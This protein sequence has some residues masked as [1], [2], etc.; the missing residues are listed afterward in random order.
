MHHDK[1]YRSTDNMSKNWLSFKT[2][3]YRQ[4][5]TLDTENNRSLKS[6]P[7]HENVDKLEVSAEDTEN[8]L[9]LSG[10]AQELS[11]K[12]ILG[13]PKQEQSSKF[14]TNK[15][16]SPSRS[17][18]D[19]LLSTSGTFSPS[20]SESSFVSRS[21]VSSSETSFVTARDSLTS[22]TCTSP[23]GDSEIETITVADGTID[24]SSDSADTL[25]FTLDESII[26]KDENKYPLVKQDPNKTVVDDFEIV[27]ID[28]DKEDLKSNFVSEQHE[29]VE[30]GNVDEHTEYINSSVVSQDVTYL[31]AEESVSEEGTSRYASLENIYNTVLHQSHVD[32][33]EVSVVGL[34]DITRTA[35]YSVRNFSTT[36][37]PNQSCVDQ[38]IEEITVVEPIN[39]TTAK[40][41]VLETNNPNLEKSYEGIDSESLNSS[42]QTINES[43][44]TL[45]N[46]TSSHSDVKSPES[47]NA[48]ELEKSIVQEQI[49]K[50][51]GEIQ[52]D[53]INQQ[54]NELNLNTEFSVEEI[55]AS[56]LKLN[57]EV[58]I[59]IQEVVEKVD[60]TARIENSSD[61][62]GEETSAN[63]IENP[64]EPTLDEI[65]DSR[66]LVV[67]ES[68]PVPQQN[69][70]FIQQ[71]DK[72]NSSETTSEVIVET[73]TKEE[74]LIVEKEPLEDFTENNSSAESPLNLSL[75]QTDPVVVEQSKEEAVE[76]EPVL[77]E[78]VESKEASSVSVVKELAEDSN[79]ASDSDIVVLPETVNQT[80]QI[81]ECSIVLNVKNEKLEEYSKAEKQTNLEEHS[82]ESSVNVQDQLT[83]NSADEV[84]VADPKVEEKVATETKAINETRLNKTF[85]SE[86]KSAD[87]EVVAEL[88][89]AIT[90]DP[91]I[92]SVDK[93]DITELKTT[94]TVDP[95]IKSAVN[96][97]V[98][99]PK[100]TNTIEPE[101]KSAGNEVITDLKTTNTAD[102]EIKSADNEV[103]AAPETTNT[104]DPDIKSADN[105]VVAAPE[106]TN[107]V[108]PDIKSADNEVVAAPETINTVDPEIKSV[109]KEVVA[110][111]KTNN[112]VDPEIKSA[113][114]EVVAELKTTNKV[115][116]EVKSAD[117]EVITDLKTTNSVEPENK[118]DDKEVVAEP[119]TDINTKLDSEITV[120]E[121]SDN[122]IVTESENPEKQTSITVE[123]NSISEIESVAQKA[124]NYSE[125]QENVSEQVK[126]TA[127][128][129]ETV[130]TNLEPEIKNL[131][132]EPEPIPVDPT[133][134]K[135]VTNEAVKVAEI[136]N[137]S[138]KETVV[139][140]E[141][142]NQSANEAVEV[143]EIP[144]Q[145][146]NEAVEIAE[147]HSV[148]FNSFAQ[149]VT[150]NTIHRKKSL[151]KEP[152]NP[153]N[154]SLGEFEL[155][156]S[157]LIS[158]EK[159]L[160]ERLKEEKELAEDTKEVVNLS[161]H[162]DRDLLE[163]EIPVNLMEDENLNKSEAGPNTAELS[164]EDF[165]TGEEW[166][167]D[168]GA[169]DFL[170][171][172]APISESELRKQSLYVQFDPFLKSPVRQKPSIKSPPIQNIME[173]ESLNDSAKLLGTSELNESVNSLS[174]KENE[175]LNGN[176]ATSTP[177]GTAHTA[178]LISPERNSTSDEKDKLIE[179]LKKENASYQKMLNDYENTITQCVNQRENDKKQFEKYKKELEKEK[180]EVQLHLRN[181]EIAFNDV[182]L[183]Y[184]R[185]KVI[186]E[187]MK[188][189][190][191]H[192]RARHS[193]LEEELKKQVNKYDALKTHA[194]SQLEK[195]NQDL[196]LRN[197]TYE[198]ETTK[199][200]AMLKKSEM[201]ITSLQESLARKTEENAELTSICDD[202]ISKV[203]PHA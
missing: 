135:E 51:T 203:G 1:E 87:K 122:E 139:V 106:T 117:N 167:K 49:Y 41:D 144:N 55:R 137:Q 141:I 25:N 160:S 103:V 184:E 57:S 193:E 54:I 96:E 152:F 62:N 156:E 130:N 72:S 148:D 29:K 133:A 120:Q 105:E 85:E 200:K 113:D 16:A 18:N 63:E 81:D 159:R 118:S 7:V 197:K 177:S 161:G 175:S 9:N 101:I 39:T 128:T 189:N 168:P 134:A 97:V 129:K 36:T 185:S 199:L 61:K 115:V 143:P 24:L 2:Q 158:E 201:Q 88:K 107:T 5:N 70:S 90:V 102:P 44:I 180:E 136:P 123:P 73:S 33:Y 27:D 182:H 194:I 183:K 82:S 164:K 98:A 75:K 171:N 202:L 163:N 83:E 84:L 188:A 13:T 92:E 142:P 153:H 178:N 47:L 146:A 66:N 150:Q 157:Q 43:H 169:F 151:P 176:C 110:E 40:N 14:N 10:L 26:P 119:K 186:I 45:N 94:N 187:G 67:E 100:T 48:G 77:T 104:V 124:E 198:M 11:K 179:K 127:I 65:Q 69:Q 149:Q 170:A 76:T 30:A 154:D 12:L 196:D 6:H 28:C 93:E 116:A 34:N 108:D 22:N 52:I 95:E 86:I 111:P 131:A 190:E 8:S 32:D 165:Q 112:T 147:I 192:L 64:K 79:K 172:R 3:I 121:K 78:K 35:D 46:T 68:E 140:A 91:E 71:V 4:N 114:N 74:I 58:N 37:F 50:S 23:N 59:G 31:S 166:F 173:E 125:S 145:S 38:Y 155:A 109:D 19:S 181:S 80:P 15:W 174:I 53:E 42:N 132:V 17:A 20:N 162:S 191:D 138:A 56:G 89:T 126:S 195:A 99:E 21:S 60:P